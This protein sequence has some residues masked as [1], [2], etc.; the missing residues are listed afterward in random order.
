MEFYV[1][2]C[3]KVCVGKR[4]EPFVSKLE[5]FLKETGPMSLRE[6]QL[7]DLLGPMFRVSWLQETESTNTDVKRELLAGE[8]AGIL[9]CLA[10]RQTKGKGTRGRVWES[11]QKALLVSIGLTLTEPIPSLMPVLG[12]DV[13]QC[14]RQVDSR[15]RVK[16]PNDLWIEGKNSEEFSAKSFI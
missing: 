10:D 6:K 2:C 14:C 3:A 13:M 11:E 7:S 15:V 1:F 12:W 4:Q 8:Q 9:V 5:M 16:W